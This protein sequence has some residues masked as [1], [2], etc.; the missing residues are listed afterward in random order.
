MPSS[1]A[2]AVATRL[3]RFRQLLVPIVVFAFGFRVSWF[4]IHGGLEPTETIVSWD[5]GD[6]GQPRSLST[7]GKPGDY[8]LWVTFSSRGAFVAGRPI[9]VEAEIELQRPG[10]NQRELSVIFPGASPLKVRETSEGLTGERLLNAVEASINL[11]WESSMRATGSTDLV[12]MAPKTISKSPLS[13]FCPTEGHYTYGLMAGRKLQTPDMFQR[14]NAVLFIAP[15]ETKIVPTTNNLLILLSFWGIYL[16][17]I[18]MATQ[19]K[20]R[21]TDPATN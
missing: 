5:V 21:S 19:Y 2:R 6:F 8:Y 9:H 15:L 18:Q 11:S 16:A 4:I 17:I 13:C 14:T 1:A 12:Y 20:R 3:L 7:V 10:P